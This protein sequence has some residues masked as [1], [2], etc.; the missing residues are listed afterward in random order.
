M[1]LS[2]E[3]NLFKCKNILKNIVNST[4]LINSFSF[5]TAILE[6]RLVTGSKD[7]FKIL[8]LNM[9]HIPLLTGAP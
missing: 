7:H 8:S 3:K 4:K 9:N 1:H 5:F 2:N 6:F